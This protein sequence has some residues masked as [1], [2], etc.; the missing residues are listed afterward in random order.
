MNQFE[1]LWQMAQEMATA[2]GLYLYKY[3]TN[4]RHNAHISTFTYAIHSSAIRPAYSRDCDSYKTSFKG[5]EGQTAKCMS[6]QHLQK[7]ISALNCLP[8]L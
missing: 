5:K 2:R 4:S 7:V 3:Q 8:L 6:Y 1:I